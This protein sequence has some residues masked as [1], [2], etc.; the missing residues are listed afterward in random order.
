MPFSGLKVIY[1]HSTQNDLMIFQAASKK[2]GK[3]EETFERK[4]CGW[5]SGQL[6]G[7]DKVIQVAW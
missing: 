2:G 6:Q 5:R 3:E 4:S 7:I 1:V